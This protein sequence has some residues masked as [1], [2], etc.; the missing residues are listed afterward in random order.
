M[1]ESLSENEIRPQHLKK[2]QEERYARD[3]ARLMLNKPNFVEVNCPAC[4]RSE[5]EQAFQK[6]GL[7]F[8]KCLGCLTIYASPRPTFEHMCDY[9]ANSENYAYW[10]QYIFPASEAMRTEKIFKPRVDLVIDLCRRFNIN[11]GLLVE[12]GAGFG[13]FCR[14]MASRNYF[15]RLVALEP[16]PDLAATCREEGI[17]TF[18]STIEQVD[19]ADLLGSSNKIDVIASFEVIE[20]LFAPT[21]FIAR[22]AQLL[23]SGGLLI[24]TCPNSAGFDIETLGA[25]SSA[26]D[27]EHVNLFNPQSLSLLCESHG[28]TVVEQQTPGRLD[29]EL[30]RDQVLSG[31]FSIENQPFLEKV[32]INEWETLGKPFQDFLTANKLSSNMLIAAIK[33]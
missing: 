24:L 1:A 3:V 32:L 9:Y 20:H 15:Q 5:T 6:L 12:I 14:E 17:E 19:S 7:E 21:D 30:V 10:N 4:D 28:F 26:V 33:N 2:G 27:T 13:T 8:V 29:A 23:P 22:C 11:P 31:T 25:L 16:T 18:E